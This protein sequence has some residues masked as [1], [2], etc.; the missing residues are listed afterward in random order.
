[1]FDISAIIWL[2]IVIYSV[3]LHE[4]AHGWM[5]YRL[6]DPTAA[7]AGR[8]TLNPIA[9]VDPFQT[10]LLPL[11]L[12]TMSGGRA[13]LGG[14][15]PVPVNP[16]MMRNPRRAMMLVGAAGPITNIAIA[17]TLSIPVRVLLNAGLSDN[18]VFAGLFMAAY[19]NVFLAAFNLLPIPPLDGSRLAAGLLPWRF[20]R[21]FDMAERFGLFFV[22]IFVLMPPFSHFTTRAMVRLARVIAYLIG[23][24]AEFLPEW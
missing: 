14:A 12:Y 15:K 23:M 17:A 2:P 9:H 1:M 6:G 5:A 19:W 10:I 24:P 4:I 13:L 18:I 16:M 11:L 21:L 7:R 3:I 20:A 22:A 8:L